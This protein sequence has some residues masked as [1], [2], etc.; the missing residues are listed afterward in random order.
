MPNEDRLL[1]L[2]QTLAQRPLRT[3]AVTEVTGAPLQ[4]VLSE[5]NTYFSVYRSGRSSDGL[6]DRIELRV[7]SAEAEA[8]HGLLVLEVSAATC[9]D[10]NRVLERFGTEREINVPNPDQ[11]PDS[12]LYLVYRD[13]GVELRFGFAQRGPQC[14]MSVVIDATGAR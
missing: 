5:S 12:P 4:R 13:S 10:K 6:L 7:P 2:V 8:K 11:P 1:D 9:L 14:L 3:E